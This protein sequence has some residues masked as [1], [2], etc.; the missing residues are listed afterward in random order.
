MAKGGSG[1]VLSGMIAGLLGQHMEPEWAVPAAVWL[2]GA[3]GDLAA[4]CYGEYGMLPSDMILKIP[5]AI[6]LGLE[7]EA[8]V[9]KSRK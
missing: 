9:R 6:Q 8:Q 5:E 4:N 2:H 3:A 1:D 7:N